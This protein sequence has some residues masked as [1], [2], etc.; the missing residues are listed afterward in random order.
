MSAQ[1]SFTQQVLYVNDD[2]GEVW[3]ATMGELLDKEQNSPSGADLAY[4]GQSI[5]AWDNTLTNY[6]RTWNLEVV[7]FEEIIYITGLRFGGY[8]GT[9]TVETHTGTATDASKPIKYDVEAGT[10]SRPDPHAFSG[11]TTGF[12]S[13]R[14]AIA[15]YDRVFV[16]NIYKQSATAFRYPS[17][18]YFS[19]AG[20]A[21]TFQS[22]AYMTVGADDGSEIT[23]I[24][25]MGEGIF[26]TKDNSCWLLL[27]T[28]DEEFA[29]REIN[30]EMGCTSTKA[31]TYH[32]GMVYFFDPSHGLMRYDGA[33]FVNVSEP[34]NEHLFESFNY[35]SD[36][37]VNVT[38][39]EDRIFLSVPTGS[40]ITDTVD[41]TYV[42]DTRLK[43]WTK[44]D[45][46]IPCDIWEYITDH[47]VSGVGLAGAGDPY[48]GTADGVNKGVFRLD[49][50]AQ[51]DETSGGNQAVVGQV[52]TGWFGGPNE[53]GNRHRL[54]RIDAI[55]NAGSHS[56]VTLNAY[57]DH[58]GD[59][60]FATHSYT[61]SGI[62][63]KWHEQDQSFDLTSTM[64]TW[65]K[66]EFS[67]STATTQAEVSSLQYSYSSRPWHRGVQGTIGKAVSGG[68]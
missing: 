50:T 26:I 31:V 16:G 19:D 63:D 28:N 52:V 48:C 22:T 23:S 6:F 34:I 46:G 65:L 59:A 7:V 66:I 29:L 41:T 1:P 3:Q 5:G 47:S 25:K 60:A 39:D 64:W 43:V 62:G 54:R 58:D 18:I 13:A 49:S 45:F 32:Q 15:A 57:R 20:T 14:C 40:G 33:N 36:F 51:D 4:S 68:G 53:Y 11:G 21:E 37:K 12:P 61:P 42:Y 17:R 38:T 56:A 67:F 27:G 30:P 10:W 24:T 8:S 44:W 35:E 9:V 2:D 55:T